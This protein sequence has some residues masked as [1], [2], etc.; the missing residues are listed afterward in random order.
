MIAVDSS[1]LDRLADDQYL[2]RR[3][4]VPTYC[5]TCGYNLRT[6]SYVYTCPE[7]GNSYNA[8]PLH[9]VNIFL[10]DQ[11]TFPLGDLISAIIFMAIGLDFAI[12][13]DAFAAILLA[14]KGNDVGNVVVWGHFGVAFFLLPIG[15]VFLVKAWRGIA[16]F[17]RARLIV[18]RIRADEEWADV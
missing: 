13:S 5:G 4:N 16:R 8:R 14:L 15:A 2:N 10:P 17:V 6:L 3:I 9:M 11:F 1:E 7:C 18:R 12:S